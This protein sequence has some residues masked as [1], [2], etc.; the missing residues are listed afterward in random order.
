VLLL[1]APVLSSRQRSITY[2]VCDSTSY[3]T[4]RADI[5]PLKSVKCLLVQRRLPHLKKTLKE[6]VRQPNNSLPLDGGGLA[7]LNAAGGGPCEAGI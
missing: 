3:N 6:A 5:G 1:K 2:A 7:L 4:H